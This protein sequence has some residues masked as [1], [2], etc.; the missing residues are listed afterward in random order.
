MAKKVAI[1][2]AG[3]SGLITAIFCAKDGLEVDLFE[4][5]TKCGKKILVSGNGRCN[6][7]NTTF[8]KANYICTNPDFVTPALS[9]FDF[10][11]FE[12]F[13]NS[14]GLLLDKKPDGRCYPMSNEAKSV[15]RLFE[16]S[17]KNL[18]VNIILQMHID[19]P[20]ILLE[21]YDAVVI[22]T[23]SQAASHLGGNRDG[24]KFA[25]SFGHSVMP[26]YP[27][28]VQLHLDST[29]A[30]KM[31]G[32]KID[33]EVSLLINKELEESVKGDILFTNYGISGFSVLDIS[34]RASQA[35]LNYEEVE[36]SLNL[37][38]NFNAQTLSTH[39]HY[40]TQNNPQLSILDVLV[41]LL[42]IKI[43]T[44]LLAYLEI[45]ETSRGV[46]VGMKMAKKIANTI[47]KWR[48][49]VSDTHGF[50]HAEA[51]G[52]GVNTYEI[53]SK[54]MESL[55]QPRLYFVGEVLDVVGHRGGYNFAWAWASGVA[56]AK[57]I[58]KE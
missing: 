43:V 47:L 4:Q 35:L 51:S 46:E 10:A 13:V 45:K 20:K 52:G 14:L 56:A 6:I 26:T 19:N 57:S 31:S 8:S 50:R 37:L 58:T 30:P 23:G 16:E 2:G 48:F 49:K 22:A 12:R 39:I 38:P 41:G 3:A 21:K 7:T 18:G 11:H 17:A 1:V 15:A 9:A 29:V 34:A 25:E 28:L 33:G 53:N 36:V 24:M 42:P 27:T 40:V 5:N 55:I 32:A 44:T 54:T